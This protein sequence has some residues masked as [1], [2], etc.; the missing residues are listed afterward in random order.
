MRASYAEDAELEREVREVARVRKAGGEIETIAMTIRATMTAGA[1]SRAKT[2][3][4]AAPAMQSVS[5]GSA[6]GAVCVA[7]AGIRAA[8]ELPV[9]ADN[10]SGGSPADRSRRFSAWRALPDGRRA[11]HRRETQGPVCPKRDCRA[12]CS[13]SSSTARITAS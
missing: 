9:S 6:G 5:A 1:E 4:T 13:C 10:L 7:H 12:Q 8:S 3:V 2:V 11:K